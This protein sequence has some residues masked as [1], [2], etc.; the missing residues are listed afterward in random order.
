MAL[1]LSYFVCGIPRSGTS[2]LCSALRSTRVAGSPEEYFLPEEEELLSQRWR[3]STFA[4]YVG[5]LIRKTATANGV[6]GAK[7]MWHYME[8][9]LMRLTATNRG[10]GL[11]GHN[12]LAAWFG[13]LRYVRVSRRDHVA[14]AVSWARALQSDVWRTGGDVRSNAVEFNFHQ[15]DDLV[16]T[17]ADHEACWD[18]FFFAAEVVPMHVFYEDFARDLEATVAAVLAYIGVGPAERPVTTELTR[19]R[20]ALNDEWVERYRLVAERSV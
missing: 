11:H 18:E 19:Q 15:I 7:V 9:F 20:D 6:F 10:A 12:L 5:A 13:D 17:I 14:Q 3:T 16:K 1:K 4:E 8:D 2:L